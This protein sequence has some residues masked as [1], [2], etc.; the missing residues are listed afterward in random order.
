MNNKNKLGVIFFPAF[1]WSISPTHPEREE[2][3]LYTQDQIFEEGLNDF[4]NI[5]FYNPSIATIKDI[6][7]VHIVVP[8]VEKIVSNSHLASAGGA[9]KAMNLVMEKSTNKAFAL[10]RPPGHHA[11]TVVYGDRGFCIVNN[12]AIMVEKLRQLYGNLKVAIVDT[13]CHHGDG[14]QDVFWNDKNTLVISLHQDGRTLYP[15]SGFTDELGSPN[16]YGY[17]I[18]IPLPP[19]TSDKGYL[20][21]VDNVVLPILKDFKPD[22]IINSAGQDNHYSDPLTN[23]NLSALGYAKL[24]EK[25]NPNIAVLEGG[26][27]ILGALPYINVGIIL[28]MSNNDYSNV[29]EPDFNPNK[30]A[31]TEEVTNYITQLSKHILYTWKNKD[32][33]KQKTYKPLDVYVFKRN[34]YYDTSNIHEQQICSYYTCNKCSSISTIDSKNNKNDHIFSITIP[35]DSCDSCLEKGKLLYNNVSKNKYT[36]VFLQNKKQDIYMNK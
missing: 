14:T 25:L 36:Q 3:L 33:L 1:D 28:A 4:S 8:S 19:N 18:N 20:Y 21:I 34:V 22:I 27:S 35:F 29:I 10:I 15:G 2:R 7:R 26:Y 16:A 31:Q 30:T 13:D 9:I 32:I 24:N 23:M 6:K 11:Q 17:N 5:D 12:V